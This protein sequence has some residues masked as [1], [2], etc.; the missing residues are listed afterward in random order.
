VSGNVSVLL[1][2]GA[3]SDVAVS[4]KSVMYFKKLQHLHMGLNTGPFIQPPSL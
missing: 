3:Q 4:F 1:V 2:P